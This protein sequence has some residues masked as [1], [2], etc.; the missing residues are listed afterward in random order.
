MMKS[1]LPVYLPA[2][3]EM[4]GV[5]EQSPEFYQGCPLTIAIPVCLPDPTNWEVT[6]ILKSDLNSSFPD[7]LGSNN[8]GVTLS[9]NQV[10]IT[11]T[12]SNSK[13]ILPGIYHLTLIGN[14]L[15]ELNNSKILFNDTIS[16]IQSAADS[17]A[18][19]QFP[20]NQSNNSNG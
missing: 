12:E 13:H 16:I 8:T 9:I 5:K 6:A 18:H 10:T 2:T 19:R 20:S 1:H 7:W 3:S 15:N 14:R 11:I 17:Y 4:Y